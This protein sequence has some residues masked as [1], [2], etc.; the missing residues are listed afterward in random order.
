MNTL[1]YIKDEDLSN[2]CNH[3]KFWQFT[4]FG[5]AAVRDQFCF[6]TIHCSNSA[7][8]VTVV[9]VLCYSCL[10]NAAVNKITRSIWK[11]SGPFAT[12]SR[13]TPIQQMSLAVLSRATCASMSTTPTTT[14]TTRDRGDRYGPMEWAQ[15]HIFWLRFWCNSTYDTTSARQTSARWSNVAANVQ[16]RRWPANTCSL[17]AWPL[18]PG[19]RT[20][21]PRRTQWTW[22]DLLDQEH[23]RRRRTPASRWRERCRAT[24]LCATYTTIML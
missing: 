15:L 4:S 24:A 6:P 22:W 21:W 9:R 2:F 13:L 7:I 23:R 1:A 5:D 18:D 19:T 8:L 3:V 16:L 11:M 20:R 17:H 12:T 10:R 14:T